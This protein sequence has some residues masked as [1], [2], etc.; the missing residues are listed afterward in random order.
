MKSKFWLELCSSTTFQRLFSDAIH[1]LVF[2][3]EGQIKYRILLDE[4]DIFFPPLYSKVVHSFNLHRTQR[5]KEKI[6]APNDLSGLQ[7]FSLFVHITWWKFFHDGYLHCVAETNTRTSTNT[8][9]RT[10]KRDS[11]LL[12]CQ[13][14]RICLIIRTFICEWANAHTPKLS[15]AKTSS[16]YVVHKHLAI[17]LKANLSQLWSNARATQ[18]YAILWCWLKTNRVLIFVCSLSWPT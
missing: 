14:A 2:L 5:K 16:R 1:S 7:F 9:N 4:W 18:I 8:F 6:A 10:N 15:R 3:W 13:W 12:Y 11:Y 17:Y